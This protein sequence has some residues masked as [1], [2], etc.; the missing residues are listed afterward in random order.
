[1]Y[2]ENNTIRYAKKS[3]NICFDCFIDKNDELSKK[4]RSFGFGK[5]DVSRYLYCLTL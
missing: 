1:M 5:C 3:I 4:Y 2:D